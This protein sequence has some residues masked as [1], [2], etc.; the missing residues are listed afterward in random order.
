MIIVWRGKGGLVILIVIAACVLM[1]ML[2]VSMFHDNDYFQ[3]HGW[4]KLA[5]LWVAGLSCWLLGNHL[6]KKPARIMIDKATG[7][8]I[9]L[10]PDHSLFFLKM[11]YWACV[12]FV[13]GLI[14]AMMK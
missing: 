3:N 14:V 1:N 10:R 6:N 12:L 4:P 2:T 13:L 11:E 5:A 9:T 7:Q 8:E